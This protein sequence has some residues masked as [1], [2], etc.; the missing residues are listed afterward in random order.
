MP[1]VTKHQSGT[2]GWLDLM[3]PDL[4]VAKKFYGGLFGWSFSTGSPETGYYTMCKLGGKNVAGMGKQDPGA[5]RPT[6]W[7]VYFITEDIEATARK[8]S[9][10]GGK[11]VVGPMSV[12]DE[13]RMAVCLD[14]TGA[15]FGLWQGKSHHGAQL[16]EEPGAMV[17]HEVNTRNAEAARDFY[18]TVMGLEA[19][20]LDAP[21]VQYWTLNNSGKAEAGVMQMAGEGADVTPPYW[22][23]YFAVADADASAKKVSDLGGQVKVPPF[24]TA[25]GRIAVVTDPMGATFAIIKPAPAEP[26]KK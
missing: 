22:L 16:V 23:N 6:Y 25:Y 20:K 1:N 5:P 3:T 13:G 18:A 26:A 11:L 21:G 15:V 2:P 12:Q 17:W 9:V 19:Q 7:S 4:E 8:V 24:D 14:P 10:S